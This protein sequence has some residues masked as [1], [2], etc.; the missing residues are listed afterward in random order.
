VEVERAD[1]RPYGGG[2]GGGRE[3]REARWEGRGLRGEP[4]R[5]GG[6]E[7]SVEVGMGVW[8]PGAW[9]GGESQGG[10]K[11]TKGAWGG[12]QNSVVAKFRINK[13]WGAVHGSGQKK[14]QGFLEK[15]NHR[16]RL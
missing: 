10:N 1:E 6:R 9:L 14:T 4:D 8:G 5:A 12:G 2:K 15:K 3:C 7:G 16:A 13:I 11:K